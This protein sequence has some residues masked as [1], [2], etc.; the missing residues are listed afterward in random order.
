MHCY[1]AAVKSVLILSCCGTITWRPMRR[2]RGGYVQRKRKPPNY[3]GMNISV[4]MQCKYSQC[5]TEFGNSKKCPFSLS[6]NGKTDET[7]VAKQLIISC[8]SI[9]T[10]VSNQ[11]MSTSKSHA[12]SFC[13]YMYSSQHNKQD[14]I[15]SFK[16]T[17]WAE[18]GNDNLMRQV[19]KQIW[20]LHPVS[21]FSFKDGDCD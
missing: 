7:I 8:P 4:K 3:M 17:D 14:H 11:K 1:R 19:D 2:W 12:H 10:T 16:R 21:V 9:F 13:I 6:V 20:V 18:S 5:G 15:W